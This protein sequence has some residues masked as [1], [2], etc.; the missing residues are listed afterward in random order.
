MKIFLFLFFLFLPFFPVAA[1][2]SLPQLNVDGN[3]LVTPDGSPVT[4]RGASLCSLT[5]HNPLEQLET[6]TDKRSGWNINVVRLPVQPEEW[7]RLGPD[8]YLKQQLDPAVEMCRKSGVYCIIDWHEIG[9]WHDEETGQRLES[10]WTIVAPRYAKEP[11][12]LYEIFNE[13]NGKNDRD[14]DNW[15]VFRERAQP[16]VDMVRKHAP[17]T[18]LLIGSPHWSQMPA[19]AAED[20]FQGSNLVYVAHIYG[21]W[22]AE[23]WDEL[24]GDASRTIPLFISEWGWSSLLRNRT[25]PF[26]GTRADYAEPLRAYLDERPHISWTAWSYDP[27]C[28]P[29]MTGKDKEMG[30]FVRQWLEEYRRPSPGEGKGQSVYP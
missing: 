8:N 4:L 26:Y 14:R 7:A 15:L 19:F 27:E 3:R 17:D 23:S 13:P 30:D 10:F 21:G 29:A 16:W 24:F 12:I 28:G 25:E 18:V 20:P 6:L 22:P 2:T 11:S 5:W 1:Q 9:D